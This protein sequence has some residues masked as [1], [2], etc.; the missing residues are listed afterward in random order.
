MTL[1][2]KVKA[3]IK[4]REAE[5]IG[6]LLWQSETDLKIEMGLHWTESSQVAEGIITMS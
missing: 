2:R 5:K 6:Y 1:E 4:E 3:W